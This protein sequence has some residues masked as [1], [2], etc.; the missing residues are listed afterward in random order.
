MVGPN[1]SSS[2]SSAFDPLANLGRDHRVIQ[3]VVNAFER[4]GAELLLDNASPSD[5]IRFTVFF[6]EFGDLI[7][8]QKEERI[9]LA[10]LSLHGFSAEGG[11]RAHIQ[12]QHDQERVLMTT[13]VRHAA[14]KQPWDPIERQRVADFIMEFCTFQRKHMEEENQV[15]YPALRDVLTSEESASVSRKLERFD[16]DH[17]RDG[18][19]DWL[20]SL[21]TELAQ[22]HGES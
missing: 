9:A 17:N 4:Y 10:A 14:G 8:H 15:V 3:Q 6:R 20:F 22:E 1:E 16:Q 13:I 19:L 12:D 21:A 18:Q 7:H 11:P 2:V 5:L